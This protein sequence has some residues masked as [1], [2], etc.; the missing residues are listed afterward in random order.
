MIMLT[1][2]LL[3]ERKIFLLF[4][5]ESFGPA[6]FLR[7]GSIL[8][9]DRWS[10]IPWL[11]R[12]VAFWG[13]AAVAA[14]AFF[15]LLRAY[16]QLIARWT[17]KSRA[18]AFRYV[19]VSFSPLLFL[20]AGVIQNFVFL[21]DIRNAVL[22]V[23]LG[24]T[25]ILQVS[26]IVILKGDQ[27]PRPAG[28]SAETRFGQ[29]FFIAFFVYALMASG[30]IVP[31][32]PL[33]GDEPHYLLIT[34]SIL[35]DGDINIRNN[36]Q[37]QDY[38]DFYA[39]RLDA[40]M[41]AGKKGPEYQFSR[42]SPLLS[43][44]VV[45]AY[46][47]GE[48]T[49][50]WIVREE[51]N[52]Q[53]ARRI[54]V[55]FCRLPL[56]L[57]A[58]LLSWLFLRLLM[59]LTERRGISVAA[60]ILLSFTP[61]LVFYTSLIYPEVLMALIVFLVCRHLLLR[62]ELATRNLLGMGAGI[63][64]SIWLGIKYAPLAVTMFG[65]LIISLLREKEGRPSKL[66]AFLLPQ[67]FLGGGYF[68]FLWSLYGNF[69]PASM[70]TG[71]ISLAHPQV[72]FFHNNLWEAFRCALIYFFDQR[73]GIF[74]YA[75]VLILA[76]PGF[77]LLRRRNRRA[78]WLLLTAFVAFYGFCSLTHYWGGYCPPSRP[79]LPVSW[80][81]SIF[82]AFSL[83]EAW[84]RGQRFIFWLLTAVTFLI[85]APLLKRPLLLY[86][87][88]LS[89]FF[90]ERG[91][92]SNLLTSLS[93]AFIDYRKF[94]PQLIDRNNILW[95]PLLAWIVGLTAV[96]VIYLKRGKSLGLRKPLADFSAL[97]A[98]VLSLGIVIIA[99]QFFSVRLSE[100]MSVAEKDCA[101]YFQDRNHFGEESG[102]FWT[103]G[104]SAAALFLRAP[105]RLS[106]IELSLS[107]PVPGETV[108]QVGN[109]KKTA[110]RAGEA[111]SDKVITIPSPRGFPW[112]GGYLYYLRI[113][114]SKEFV[115]A[116][117]NPEGRDSRHLGICVKVFPFL[118]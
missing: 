41:R 15:V 12:E 36:F 115:P 29:F 4:I 84:S 54:L 90:D 65:F 1:N 20:Y 76:V 22:S 72:P 113:K 17:Q 5:L 10:S 117:L 44:L 91:T 70:Y 42:H 16:G 32:H 13:L 28:S 58:A 89:F 2:S 116:E 56:C 33:T 24:G 8:G 112:K 108:V 48:K 47:L 46:F 27:F 88:N 73:I 53:L 18:E 86:H 6:V 37:G 114:E 92:W 9:L 3:G 74:A 80:I 51:E 26:L 98:V 69:S 111:R 71:T 35:S 50:S 60:W 45:P 78:A 7:Q 82:L 64:L 49:A 62:K 68:F 106:R 30:L 63:G 59:S 94:I 43:L 100:G 67:A 79:L 11:V 31:S 61:P 66:F 110:Q 23:S 14:A 25:A 52:T 87:H 77:V 107:S 104:K 83:D 96:T 118:S 95:L 93:G 102:G 21:N 109:F 38:L 75:P 19:T 34:K 55:F 99:A 39:G 101:L 57:A 97:M 103:K 40:H 85:L 105:R 81:L